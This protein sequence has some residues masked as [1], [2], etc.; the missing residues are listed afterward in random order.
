MDGEDILGVWN[1]TD[2]GYF[3]QVPGDHVVVLWQRMAS[4]GTEPTEGAGK[5]GTADKDFGKGCIK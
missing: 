5:M 1:T 2:N 3:V 4:G